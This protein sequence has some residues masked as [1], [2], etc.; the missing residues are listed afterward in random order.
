MSKSSASAGYEPP[1]DR[2]SKTDDERIKNVTPLPP[3]ST[4]SAFSRSAARQSSR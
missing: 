4:S 2:T 3:P 1:A